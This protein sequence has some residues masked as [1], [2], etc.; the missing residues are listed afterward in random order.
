ME[1]S[2]AD[3]GPRLSDRDDFYLHPLSSRKLVSKPLQIC[4]WF[5]FR[6][7]SLFY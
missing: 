1:C 3:M 5:G 7:I 6:L 2:L 4:F